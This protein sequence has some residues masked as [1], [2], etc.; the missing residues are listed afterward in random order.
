MG[1]Y[2]SYFINY[3]LVLVFGIC[4][5]KSQYFFGLWFLMQKA[6]IFVFDIRGSTQ[7]SKSLLGKFGKVDKHIIYINVIFKYLIIIINKHHIIVKF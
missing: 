3:A 6:K 5:T 1:R 2:L 7:K 4:G